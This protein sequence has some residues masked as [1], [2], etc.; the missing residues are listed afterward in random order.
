[1]YQDFMGTFYSLWPRIHYQ[2]CWIEGNDIHTDCRRGRLKD[3]YISAYVHEIMK[4]SEVQD[5]TLKNTQCSLNQIFHDICYNQTIIHSKFLM[6]YVTIEWLFVNLV[7]TW[8]ENAKFLENGNIWMWAPENCM[9][10][11]FES[12][13]LSWIG[14]RCPLY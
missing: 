5:L 1:M 8:N 3:M 4:E 6:W 9:N 10:V 12:F 7:N 11:T 13:F 2:S 14:L